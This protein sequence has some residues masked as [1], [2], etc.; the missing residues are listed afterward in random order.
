M[1]KLVVDLRLKYLFASCYRKRILI[2]NFDKALNVTGYNVN[3]DFS[4]TIKTSLLEG[5]ISLSILSC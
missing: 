5:R 3:L 1:D 4:P 2:R